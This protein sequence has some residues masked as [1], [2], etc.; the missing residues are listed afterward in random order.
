MDAISSRLHLCNVTFNMFSY[1][2]N[3]LQYMSLNMIT[4]GSHVFDLTDRM[5]TLTNSYTD[6]HVAL[7]SSKLDLLLQGTVD[8][9]NV[10]TKSGLLCI[11]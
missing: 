4:F 1:H 2:E 6:V 11:T 8:N 3:T 5:I 7:F 9:F 10:I